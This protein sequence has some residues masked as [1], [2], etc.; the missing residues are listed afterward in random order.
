M[1]LLAV[2]CYHTDLDL[3]EGQTPSIDARLIGDW[4]FPA[5]GKSKPFKLL[6]RALDEGSYYVEFSDGEKRIRGVGTVIPAK[7]VLFAQLRPLPDDGSIAQE[8]W[9]ARI[10]LGDDGK[11]G[12]QQLNPFFFYTKRLTAPDHLNELLLNNLANP[13]MYKGEFG[14]GARKA[15]HD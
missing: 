10:S 14:Y 13:E 8:R 6:V 1:P 5:S 7:D 15:Q 11:L 2:A 4:D 9:L 12:I 3:T